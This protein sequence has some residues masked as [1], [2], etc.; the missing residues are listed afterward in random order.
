[1][2]KLS[3]YKFFILA[4]LV[5]SASCSAKKTVP[6][7]KRATPLPAPAARSTTSLNS[8]TDLPPPPKP[9][10]TLSISTSTQTTAKKTRADTN[11]TVP[12]NN[13]PNDYDCYK[14]YYEN[15]VKN[16]G[17]AQAFVEL[18]TEY[19]TKTYVQSE[20]HAITHVIGQAA[21]DLYDKVSEAYAQG[22]E[23]CASGYYHGVME[24]I[25]YKMG[26]NDLP[27]QLNN[28]CA[29]IPGKERYSLGYYN[30]NHGLG[31]GLMGFTNNEL[32]ESLKLCDKLNGQWEKSSCY[33]GGFMENVIA[34]FRNHFTKYLRP[35]NPMYPCTDVDS[36]YKMPCYLIQSSYVLRLAGGDFK[37]VFEACEKIETDYRATCFQSLGRD[38]S[39]TAVS[40]I[41]I[42]KTRCDMG[43][44]YFEQSN[45]VIGAVKDVVWHF[46]S[47]SDGENFCN[48]LSADLQD[49]CN[50]TAKDYFA[51]F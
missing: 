25:I 45:C 29:D 23:F 15:L 3:K 43:K 26:R 22:D 13:C 14:T 9:P 30:C 24:S 39:G 6:E 35:E 19:Q 36:Q 12:S 4:L 10:K 34:D 28:L 21:A 20:C 18:K 47:L 5:L 32:F 31:H 37:K 42:T 7:Q 50:S 44:D 17:V 38:A 48:A 1:M 40:D 49:I 41:N 8:V 33:S 16:F 11:Q 27:N 51:T 2:T 46:H